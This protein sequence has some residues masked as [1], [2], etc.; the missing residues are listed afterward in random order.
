MHTHARTHAHTHT[1][2]V[3]VCVR[4]AWRDFRGN[5]KEESVLL[6]THQIVKPHSA[7]WEEQG[8]G[9]GLYNMHLHLTMTTYILMKTVWDL[10]F[11][12]PRCALFWYPWFI[13]CLFPEL[14]YVYARCGR[15]GWVKVYFY[16]LRLHN[17]QWMPETGVCHQTRCP[18]FV[19]LC[20]LM[21]T[22]H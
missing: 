6:N 3:C 17:V 1:L 7:G 16:F 20:I 19:A 21:S 13:F 12:L 11:M 10:H 8:G 4:I 22:W 5:L 18:S 15:G 2:C 14:F 9:G